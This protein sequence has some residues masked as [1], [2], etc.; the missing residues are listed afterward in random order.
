MGAA[1][2]GVAALVEWVVRQVALLDVVPAT[3]VVPVGEGV[4]LPEL[5]WLVPAPLRRGCARR[6]LVA[7][8]AG[9]PGVEVGERVGER[10][11]LADRA[12][13]LRLAFPE[14]VAVHRGLPAERRAFVDLNLRVVA[15]LDFL[16]ERTGL[17]E[18][19]V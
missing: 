4:R 13:E 12:A 10:G 9:D 16:P 3:G 18:E 6:R 1:D 15:P 2:R 19:D 5:V 14:R 7:A 8:Q 11:D 17:G